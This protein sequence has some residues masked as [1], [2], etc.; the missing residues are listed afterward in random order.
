MIISHPLVPLLCASAFRR[1]CSEQRMKT[2]LLL[3]FNE[4]ETARKIPQT[5]MTFCFLLISIIAISYENLPPDQ[6]SFSYTLPLHILSTV[7]KNCH[8][9]TFLRVIKTNPPKR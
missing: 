7:S 2:Y 3:M 8:F 5:N 9:Y 1:F 4:K 6:R